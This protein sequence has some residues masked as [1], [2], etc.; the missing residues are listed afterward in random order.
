[1][2]LTRLALDPRSAQ[3]R[4]DLSSPYDLHRT[5]VRAF[6]RDAEQTPP[7]FLWRLEPGGAWDAPVVLVQAQ[8]EPD[9]SALTALPGYLKGAPETKHVDVERFVQAGGRYRFRLL[10]NPTVTR[11][12]KRYGLATET[13]QLDWLGRQGARLGFAVESVLVTSSDLLE[14]RKRDMRI[15]LQRACYE[16]LLWPNDVSLL[17]G[18]LQSGIGPGKAFGCGLLS[19]ARIG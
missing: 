5:L 12:G 10:A 9:W 6:V 19:L 13:A 14:T 7:R 4:R 15:S 1:M 16:G 18:A 11:E 8:A 2:F 3:A 17:A